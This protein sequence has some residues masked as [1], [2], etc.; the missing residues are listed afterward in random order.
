MKYHFKIHK[1][2]RGYWAECIELEGCSTQ[3]ETRAE[4]ETNMSEVLNLYLSEPMTSRHLFPYPRTKISGK[5][6]KLVEVEP[7]VAIAN[8][9]RELRI[10]SHLTQQM[11]KEFLGIKNLSNYQ[12]LEDPERSNPEW[13]TLMLIKSKFPQFKLDDL[14]K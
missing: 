10:R 9:I 1:E 14:L 7:S 2:K 12:R 8:R 4:L 3:G 13:A 6:I 5:N 11:M